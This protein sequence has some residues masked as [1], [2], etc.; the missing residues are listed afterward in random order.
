[1]TS[2]NRQP[3]IDSRAFDTANSTYVP[4]PS[5]ADAMLAS[6]QLFHDVP[7]RIMNLIY[8]VVTH[9]DFDSKQ[10]TLR[11]SVDVIDVVEE[12]RLK[13]RM[14][15]VQERSAS[16]DGR[17][18]QAGFPHFILDEVLDIIHA[19][20]MNS[21]KARFEE[22]LDAKAMYCKSVHIQ[23]DDTLKAM[24]HVHRSWTM[25]A[26][27]T[28]GRV[29]HIGR[30]T[31]IMCYILP[32]PVR[33]SIFGPW[34]SAV[35]VQFFH[36]VEPKEA[37]YCER[38]E[39]RD[40][41]EHQYDSD[42]L[43][44][45]CTEVYNT[46]RCR[47]WFETLHRILVGFTS[48]KSLYIKSYSRI[49]TMW[50]NVTFGEMVR[51]NVRLEELTLYAMD[52]K[53]FDLNPL[54]ENATLLK[55]LRK[56]NIERALISDVAVR[57]AMQG[58][59]FACLSNVTIKCFC[60]SLKNDL[61]LLSIFSSQSNSRLESLRIIDAHGERTHYE[62]EFGDFGRARV[63]W[64][65]QRAAIFASL[66]VLHIDS[67][68]SAD[69]WFEWIGPYCSRL[70]SLSIRDSTGPKR[71]T[72]E[73]DVR[74]AS[75]PPQSTIV[76]D[77][78]CTL[79]IDSK[80]AANLWLKWIGPSCST[81]QS[82][83]LATNVSVTPDTFNFIPATI[84]NLELVL[85]TSEGKRSLKEV[86]G[87]MNSILNITSSNHLSKLTSFTL[88]ISKDHIRYKVSRKEMQNFKEKMNAVCE[89]VGVKCYLNF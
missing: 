43:R 42:G 63:S 26:Q 35:A 24:T 19:E 82:L 45:E 52:R 29:L 81:L 12:H 15:V 53:T 84:Q 20:R 56:L 8:S 54:L 34:T 17:V 49:L 25:L 83:T 57:N 89:G 31:D 50:F 74:R 62:E 69:K 86:T 76:F 21:I 33:K 16:R 3:F 13:D 6:L 11:N 10:L 70:E 87:W 32:S 61:V 60:T 22:H 18:V 30:P 2:D 48:L 14:A 7:C 1:M 58:P 41:S 75:F 88:F 55:N 78:L 66:R 27:K 5:Q 36:P 9:P 4:F 85:W 68:D 65:L 80:T 72:S 67:Q 64:S 39:E 73:E 44:Y 46:E 51:R 23:E 37:H 79:C 47:Q 38:C 28:L 71:L 59:G 77:H 40:E